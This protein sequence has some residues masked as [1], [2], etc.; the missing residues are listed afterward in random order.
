[1]K[2]VDSAAMNSN[3]H[4]IVSS[5]NNTKISDKDSIYQIVLSSGLV[6][7]VVGLG[8]PVQVKFLIND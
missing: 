1:M 3:L 8:E 2:S 5:A 6:A 7:S 4:K